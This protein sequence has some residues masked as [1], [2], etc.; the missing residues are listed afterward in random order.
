M[1]STQ[2]FWRSFGDALTRAALAT[3]RGTAWLAKA[4]Y[5]NR[6]YVPAVINGAIGD[7]LALIQDHQKPE[8]FFIGT[9]FGLYTTLDAGQHWHKLKGDF[10]TI[11]AGLTGAALDYGDNWVGKSQ[12]QQVE[13][14][15]LAIAP[16]LGYKVNDRLSVGF[17]VQLM[18]T[19]LD[20]EV[21]LPIPG[22]KVRLD[23]DDTIF[24][25][26]VGTM[27]ELSQDTR[28]GLTYQHEFEPEYG[29]KLKFN[30]GDEA[31]EVPIAPLE[32]GLDVVRGF[33]G[34]D[35]DGAAGGL[36]AQAR[37]LGS[38]QHLK[39]IDIHQQANH[40][41]GA[42]IVDTVNKHTDAGL[43]RVISGCADAAYLN[44][45]ISGLY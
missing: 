2:A 13:L 37:A 44:A 39:G 15:G 32:H 5:E 12:T 30:P 14:L 23:G 17:S 24:S 42:G 35:V 25:F 1:S 8:L 36:L 34:A 19:E 27:Y 3:G 18:Y 40:G 22:S 31:V 21:G 6:N 33:D 26:K 28:I 38:P 20:M 7:K 45:T 10:P 43:N 11:Q 29:G 4:G 9:E 16:S 41:A